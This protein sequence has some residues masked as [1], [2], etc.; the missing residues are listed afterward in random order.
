MAVCSFWVCFAL[1]VTGVE[2]GG[3]G[4]GLERGVTGGIGGQGEGGE[5]WHV[6]VFR[7]MSVLRTAR[8]LA[9][10]SGTTVSSPLLFFFAPC[11]RH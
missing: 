5:G 10:T 7:A 8:L 9:V 1:A 6:G 3:A 11:S 2:R 4:L